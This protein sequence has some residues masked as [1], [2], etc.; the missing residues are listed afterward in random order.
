MKRAFRISALFLGLMTAFA[1]YADQF[2]LPYGWTGGNGTTG[3]CLISNGS[4]VLPSFQSCNTGGGVVTSVGLS[5]PSVFSVTGSP[6]TSSGSISVTFAS[7]QTA[8]SFLATPSGSTGAVSLR[9]ITLADLPAST[10]SGNIVLSTSPTLV[11]P[12]LGTPSAL[13][14]TNATGLPDGALSANVP[15]L[16]AANSFTGPSQTLSSSEPRLKLNESDQGTDLKLWDVDVNSGVLCLR[17]RTDADAAGVNVLCSTRGSTT[18]ITNL[19]FGNAT[20]NPSY[21]FLG[22]GLATFSGGISS[23]GQITATAPAA[24]AGSGSIKVQNTAPQLSIT[25][26]GSATDAKTWTFEGGA[27]NVL[28]IRAINDANNVGNNLICFTRSGASL[29]DISYGNA[30]NNNTHTFLGTG[31]LSTGGPTLLKKSTV[32]ALPTCNAGANGYAEVVTDATSP[33]YNATLTGGGSVTAIAL[34]NGTNWTAH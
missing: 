2:A 34:C 7:G 24:N 25:N 13:A 21:S 33:T 17:T 6:V 30:T 1:S 23:N 10:G 32:S 5:L 20:N 18:A 9:T 28:C 29:T 14:L 31:L 27:A 22:T 3:Q 8:N 12:S 4:V 19:A 15:L 26:S 16:N 11:T